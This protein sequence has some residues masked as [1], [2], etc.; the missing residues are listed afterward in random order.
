MLKIIETKGL[1][2][3]HEDALGRLNTCLAALVRAHGHIGELLGRTFEALRQSMRKFPEAALQALENIGR[4]IFKSND[5]DMVDLFI[6]HTIALGFQCPQIR[7]TT[8]EWKVEVNPA[9]L[10]NI[11]AWL[12]LI[13]NNPKW[14][15]KLISALII[16]LKLAGL[17]IKDTDLF[18]KEISFFL[19]SDIGPVYNLAKQLTKLFPVYFNEINAEGELRDVSTEIDELSNRGDRLIHFLR[20]QSHV[21]SNNLLI[22]FVLAIIDFWRTKDK[23]GLLP[24]VPAETL[25][26]IQP[27]GPF[28]RGAHELVCGLFERAGLKDSRD[29]L[30]LD[31]DLLSGY[32]S[33]FPEGL[34]T[35][36]RR[37]L[38]LVR[39]LRLLD[40]K[41]NLMHFETERLVKEAAAKGLPRTTYLEKALQNSSLVVRL[42][43]V[44]D[45]L[46]LLKQIILSPEHFE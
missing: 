30:D 25:R 22:G 19:N 41:Y 39:F 29:L 6:R 15:K 14:S 35:D 27:E 24:Y 46:K 44:L 17:Y 9:H 32:L 2:A 13:E 18:Q 33:E 38:L 31:E 34:K 40:Q 10:A 3:I 43:G 4:E 5:S 20:K 7:G 12:H 37:L 28:V 36:K 16:N 23:G 45:Y 21:E 11:K 26:A 8:Q 42:Q 1:S